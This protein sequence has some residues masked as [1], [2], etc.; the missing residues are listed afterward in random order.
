MKLGWDSMQ[1]AGRVG[2]ESMDS[3][4]ESMDSGMGNWNGCNPFRDV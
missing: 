1:D 4:M 3:G 2:M